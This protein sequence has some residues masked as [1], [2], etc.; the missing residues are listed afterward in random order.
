MLNGQGR[1]PQDLDYEDII[2]RKE[3]RYFCIYL[4]DSSIYLNKYLPGIRRII[5]AYPEMASVRDYQFKDKYLFVSD[6]Y[7]F[8]KS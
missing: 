5:A 3:I 7:P 1:D 8:V 4:P 6:K 2:R